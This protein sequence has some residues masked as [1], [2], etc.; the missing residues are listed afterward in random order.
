M[1]A[2]AYGMLAGIAAVLGSLATAYAALAF[3]WPASLPAPALSTMVQFDEKLRYMRN[4]P[5]LD[6]KIIAIGSSIAWRQ[7]AGEVFAS[8]AGGPEH[9]VNGG[10]GNLKIHQSRRL[11]EF[12][13]DNFHHVRTILLMTGLP[14]FDDCTELPAEIIDEHD[15]AAYVFDGWP[16][17]YFYLRYFSPQR[18]ARGALTLAGRRVPFT[19]DLFL[20]EYGS[21]PL[22]VDESRQ[23]GLRY[24]EIKPD[25]ACLKALVRLSHDLTARGFN[26]MIVFAPVNPEYLERYPEAAQ[27]T[28]EAAQRVQTET[29]ADR[30]KVVLLYDDPEFVADD[31]YDAFHLQWPGVQRLSAQ[32]AEE[33]KES[34]AEWENGEQKAAERSQSRMLAF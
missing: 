10:T 19:G 5:D 31:F 3:I 33:M 23:R 12:Y 22:L 24:G 9:F 2:F 27:W 28:R 17:A 29:K 7:V 26:L 8:Q 1:K 15:A 32:V 6:P 11:L 13:L 34:V 18:Y 25:P 16:A 20:D 30:T 21:G 14:D 4:R